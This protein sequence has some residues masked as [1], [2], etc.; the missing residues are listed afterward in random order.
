[1]CA[2]G[3]QLL[4]HSDEASPILVI[5]DSVR[6]CGLV[7]RRR[8]TGT[9]FCTELCMTSVYSGGVRYGSQIP[10]F[11]ARSSQDQNYDV[12]KDC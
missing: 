12:R 5:P 8:G 2:C 11:K 7:F 4:S 1:M 9:H 3:F 6:S 10:I